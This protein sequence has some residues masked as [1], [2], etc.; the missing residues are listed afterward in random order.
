MRYLLCVFQFESYLKKITMSAGSI[1][2]FWEKYGGDCLDSDDDFPDFVLKKPI[3]SALGKRRLLS[4]DQGENDEVDS[5]QSPCSSPESPSLI[6][7]TV[8]EDICAGKPKIPRYES[9]VITDSE[10][11]ISTSPAGADPDDAG[12]PEL[13]I[14]EGSRDEGTNSDELKL[15]C[16]SGDMTDSQV[17]A[18]AEGLTKD[19]NW[20][21]KAEK[22]LD[23]H[24]TE[25]DGMGIF[26]GK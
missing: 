1:D 13:V 24:D 11:T 9:I 8:Y 17:L 14:D 19:I 7:P 3:A 2:A 23:G 21:Q 15:E 10:E 26:F 5:P 6:S 22:I 16:C 12:I 4:Q 25:F 20:I 18:A